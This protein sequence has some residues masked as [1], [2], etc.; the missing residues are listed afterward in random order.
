MK[1]LYDIKD[2]P[3]LCPKGSLFGMF[4]VKGSQ[5]EGV[6]TSFYD[7]NPAPEARP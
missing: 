6:F 2:T 4:F 5:S 7:R 1:A 3:N